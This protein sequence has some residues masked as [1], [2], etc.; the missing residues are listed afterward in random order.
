VARN[1]VTG[2]DAARGLRQAREWLTQPGSGAS[3]RRRW[4]A[5]RDAWMRLR[6]WPYAG[7]ESP[8]HPGHRVLVVEGYAIIYR[9][10][11]DTGDRATAGD[12]RLLAI[13]PPGKG[14]RRLGRPAD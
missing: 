14:D 5:V 9:I 1:V 3:G 13:F 8:E 2:S 7:P 10:E 4:R 11:C 12:V 6:D